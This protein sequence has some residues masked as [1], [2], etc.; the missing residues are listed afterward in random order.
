MATNGL[1]CGRSNHEDVLYLQT[2]FS[3]MLDSG[4]GS[5]KM[6]DAGDEIASDVKDHKLYL[7]D[8]VAK[9]DKCSCV[10]VR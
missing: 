1:T 8:I 10:R 4:K 2:S 6:A 5:E 3:K 7:D 9:D